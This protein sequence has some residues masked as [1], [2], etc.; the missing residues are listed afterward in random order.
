MAGAIIRPIKPPISFSNNSTYAHNFLFDFA[1]KVANVPN[2]PQLR[3]IK[4]T[5]HNFAR[6]RVRLTQ[7]FVFE[8]P[9][10]PATSPAE[11]YRIW[12]HWDNLQLIYPPGHVLAGQDLD[13]EQGAGVRGGR[14]LHRTGRGGQ[15]RGHGGW[16][17]GNRKH[18]RWFTEQAPKPINI[19]KDLI[20]DWKEHCLDGA[21]E[22]GED[23]IS[24]FH[25]INYHPPSSAVLSKFASWFHDRS[26]FEWPHPWLVS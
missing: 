25:V 10:R 8:Q 23:W 11:P 13:Q 21:D 2:T 18:G 1:Q 3:L 7:I 20:F 4:I 26:T 16:R 14:S 17:Q 9:P 5:V 6:P 24:E 15:G 12:R 19:P 22:N